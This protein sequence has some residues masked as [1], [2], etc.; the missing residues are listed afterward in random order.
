MRVAVGPVAATR[1]NS[2]ALFRPNIGIN[3]NLR[4]YQQ[5]I[6]GPFGLYGLVCQSPV[7]IDKNYG[8]EPD[9]R[10]E[11]AISIESDGLRL[12]DSLLRRGAG[13]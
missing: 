1:E 11:L 4:S 8:C 7:S 2:L 6:C 13:D 12:T 10:L 5:I 3:L 9:Q